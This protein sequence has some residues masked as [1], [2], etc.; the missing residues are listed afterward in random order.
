MLNGWVDNT[1][2]TGAKYFKDE[3]G[4]VHLSGDIISGAIAVGTTLLTLPVG[5]RPR[6][7]FPV[8]GINFYANQ[9][10]V[11][12][13]YT[14]GTFAIATA[15]TSSGLRFNLSFRAEN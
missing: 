2:A 13:L 7:N 11:L 8:Q 6:N 9:G 15:L 4:I 12:Q 1:L 14:D 5:Y 10:V 3:F